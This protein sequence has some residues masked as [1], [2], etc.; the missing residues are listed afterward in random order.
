MKAAVYR[1]FDGPIAVEDLRKPVAEPGG[2]VVE[3]KATGVCRSDWHGW[4]GHDSDIHDHGLPFVPGHELSGV[5]SEVGDGVTRFAVG[6]R[7]AVPFIL[8]CGA[9]VQC[10]RARPTV[11]E[12]Q[13][14]PGFT[15][16]GSFAQFVALPRADRNLS[17]L[18]DAVSFVAAAALGCR[19]TTAYRATLQQGRLTAGETCVVFGAGGVGLSCI[20]I[21]VAHGAKVI[22]VDVNEAARSKALALG[23][24]AAVDGSLPPLEVRKQVQELCCSRSGPDLSVDAAG[25]QDSCENAVY[26]TGRGGRMVQIG[27]PL[28]HSNAPQIPMARVANWELELIGSHG[29]DARDFPAILE[30][31]AAGKLNPSAL[32]E[33]EVSLAEGCQALH[34]MDHGS[35]LGMTVI[36]SFS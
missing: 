20:M 27:L 32:V 18:P 28:G 23:A 31:V 24:V 14:Q 12:K 1:A 33:K 29:C 6:D 36:T 21:G 10:S 7:V 8:S 3:V 5:V 17:P 9:C 2:V 11:C 19:T 26:C 34:D 25:F 15:M 35:P 16:F 4:K 30:M 13:Q 22:A